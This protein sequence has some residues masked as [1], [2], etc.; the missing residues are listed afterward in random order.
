MSLRMKTVGKR[1][2]DNSPEGCHRRAL[3]LMRELEGA[4]PHPRPRGFV[5]KARN[6][7][8]YETWRAAQKNPRLW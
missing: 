2:K 8:E 6:R 4:N 7:E 5:F 3:A 1:Q